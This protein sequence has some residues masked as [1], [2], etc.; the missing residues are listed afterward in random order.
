MSPAVDLDALRRI[1]PL[2]PLLR[3]VWR[4]QPDAS[5]LVLRHLLVHG[6]LP[7][8]HDP[9]GITDKLLWR[10][11]FDRRPILRRFVD[12]CAARA[13]VRERLGDEALL[14][15]LHAVLDGAEALQDL[16]LPDRFVAKP[17]HGSGWVWVEDGTRPPDR[18]GLAA[19]ARHWLATDYHAVSRE[20]AYR[21]LPRRLLVEEHLG[22]GDGLPADYKFFCYDGRALFCRVLRGRF[23]EQREMF[24]DRDWRPLPLTWSWARAEAPDPPPARLGEM[25]A[26]ADQLSEGMDFLRVDLFHLARGVRFGELTP[27]PSGAQARIDPP[28]WDLRLG[29]PWRLDRAAARRGAERLPHAA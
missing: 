17:S 27:Y 13:F 21:G 5:F 1:A 3:L 22:E 28:D 26:V 16:A 24:Y 11:L 7:R 12:K 15:R 23:A 4:N 9:Q 20:W 19:A 6:R 25:L 29:E 8:L 18:D 2:R 14:P 10:L